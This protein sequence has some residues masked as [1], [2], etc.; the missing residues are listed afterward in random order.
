MIKSGVQRYAAEQDVAIV[1]PDTS[2]RPAAPLP[3]E[4][5]AWDFGVGAG[6]YLN[7]TNAPYADRGYHMYDYVVKELP[8]L[9][10]ANLPLSGAFGIT[11]HSMGGH[12]ALQIGLKN[13]ASGLFRSISAFSPIAH[14]SVG[15]WGIKAFS[16]YLGAD[17]GA[18]WAEYD[19]TALVAAHGPALA[20]TLP[21]ILID[22]GAD[23]E[24]LGKGEL[25]GDDFVAAAGAAGVRV[26]YRLHPGYD[27]S[28][29][30]ISTF[31][32]DHVAHH[33]RILK[34]TSA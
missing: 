10:T 1:F 6:F 24:F 5:A 9:L 16:N 18:S 22:Q 13:F 14:P 32:A 25:R 15:P 19:A 33:A 34:G 27:H 3:Q 12:G 11:G 26:S 7:A 29:Y 4:T 8:P 20:A 17:N 2:P 30:F 21:P 28:Y 23:D 31:I